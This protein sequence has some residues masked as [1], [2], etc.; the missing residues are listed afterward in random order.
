MGMPPN[1]PGGDTYP[2]QGAFPPQPG[3]QPFGAPLQ[4]GMPGPLY[5]EPQTPPLATSSLVCGIIGL[6]FFPLVMSIVAV[7][8]GHMALNQIAASQGRLRGQGMATAGLI[9][10][11]IGI[12]ITVLIVAVVLVVLLTVGAHFSS[13]F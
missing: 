5:L 7:I 13:T 8:C 4:P 9:L 3:Y 12:G 11:Y 6:V 1:M 10:G 2:Q